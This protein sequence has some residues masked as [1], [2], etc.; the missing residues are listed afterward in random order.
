MLYSS[1]ISTEKGTRLLSIT[2]IVLQ[3]VYRLHHHLWLGWSL[4]R[5][6]GV[7]L[8][9]A[10][11]VTLIRWW[12]QPCF[13][14]SLGGLFIVY[15]L[16]LAWAARLRYVCFKPFA[17]ASEV[18]QD[19]PTGTPLRPEALV[20][21]RVSGHFSVHGQEQYYVNVEA[22][23]ETVGSREHIILGRIHPSRFL[24][25]GSWPS[26]EVGWWYAFFQPAMLRRIDIGNLHFGSR[27]QQAIR[28]AYAQNE[29]TVETLYLAFDDLTAL[30]RV[31]EDIIQDAPLEVVA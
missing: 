3:F 12:W 26:W 17:E 5:W 10:A 23:F 4:A 1:H 16:V 25:L 30:R 27:A 22:N 15:L 28:I 29:D 9:G 21:T 18:L 20:P 7:L 6:F 2:G 8:G 24:L 13:P 31:W 11:L 14:A 19:T